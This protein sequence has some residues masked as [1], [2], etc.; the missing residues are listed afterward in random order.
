ME[1]IHFRILKTLKEQGTLAK[2]AETLHLTQSALSH[3]IKNLEK[4]LALTLWQKHG[5]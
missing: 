5:R 3:Q 2:T 1:L 4:R